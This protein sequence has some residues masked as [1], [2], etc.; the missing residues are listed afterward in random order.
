MT[1][2][3]EKPTLLT[4]DQFHQCLKT[5]NSDG[6]KQVLL[7]KKVITSVKSDSDL[8]NYRRINELESG[9]QGEEKHSELLSELKDLYQK[10]TQ[11]EIRVSLLKEDINA[12]RREKINSED[13]FNDLKIDYDEVQE[14][15]QQYCTDLE[16][17]KKSYNALENSNL[18][19][20]K[21]HEVLQEEYLQI[22]YNLDTVTQYLAASLTVNLLGIAY[23]YFL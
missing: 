5:T 2:Y 14:N 18:D 17:S 16:K 1:S 12:I 3:T 13:K 22:K 11:S 15:S 4:P 21:I 9:E 23:Y 10:Y 19:L 6:S 20:I 8:Q 7:K